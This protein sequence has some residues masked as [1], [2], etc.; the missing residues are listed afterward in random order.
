[1]MVT[2][3]K[4]RVRYGETDKMGVVYHGNYALYFEESRTD[5]LRKIDITYKSLEDEGVMM[6]VVSLSTDFKR[7]AK[8]DDLLTIRTIM[9]T[10]PTAKIMLEYEV[11]NETNELLATGSSTL[12]FVDMKTNRPT[13]CPEHL[14]Q[15]FSTYFK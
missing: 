13:R 1:M 7:P 12:V 4:I 14:Y 5:A 15:K 2:E 6:P 10:L 3:T 9:R 11:L 8:Y